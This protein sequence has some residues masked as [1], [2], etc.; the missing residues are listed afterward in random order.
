[1]HGCTRGATCI[2][3]NL[4]AAFINLVTAAG[5][6]LSTGLDHWTGLLDWGLVEVG[7]NEYNSLE[8]LMGGH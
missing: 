7:V 5:Q 6:C 8:L 4:S 3:S 2:H 1:M